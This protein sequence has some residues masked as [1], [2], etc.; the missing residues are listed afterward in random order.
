MLRIVFMLIMARQPCRWRRR[1]VGVR[2]RSWMAVRW[3]W[4]I[5]WRGCGAGRTGEAL[6]NWRL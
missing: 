3:G 1:E 4:R 6:S 2:G 5:H